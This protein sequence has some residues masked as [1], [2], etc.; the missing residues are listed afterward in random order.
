MLTGQNGILNQAS[1]A[2][3]TTIKESAREEVHLE[4]N[5]SFDNNGNYDENK[6][7]ENLKNNLK[8]PEKD[9]NKVKGV[10]VVKY[11]NYE[12]YNDSKVKI[13]EGV[14]SGL[15]ANKPTEYYGKFVTNYTCENKDATKN[16][17]IF[18]ADE[19]NIYLISDDYIHYNY[20]P[21]GKKGSTITTKSTD[22]IVTFKNVYLDYNVSDI[23][24]SKAKGILSYFSNNENTLT[25]GG[26]TKSLA[27]ML[28]TDAWSKFKGDNAEYAIGGP[29]LDL[30][31]ASYNEMNPNKQ[32]GYIAGNI[33]Y[34]LS[35]NGGDYKQV[36]FSLG[37]NQSLYFKST[38]NGNSMWLAS[39]SNGSSNWMLYV[40]TT[41]G[42][43]IYRE[44]IL[45]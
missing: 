30:F 12:Y 33:G 20:M 16:W 41:S 43:Q 5:G 17:Q 23:E 11:T 36:L 8:I 38:S 7:I 26:N 44:R 24:N 9:I 28:D 4:V 39:T 31:A 3:E 25:N 32:I 19:N 15:I 45:W 10:L 2:K 34:S 40:N 13:I 18:Y 1:K 29:T 6:A 35:M 21:S 14:V 37:A 42:G 22:Y 27:Y